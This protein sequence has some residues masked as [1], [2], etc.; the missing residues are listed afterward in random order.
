MAGRLFLFDLGFF[1]FHRF[2]RID[3]NGGFFVSRLKRSRIQKSSKSFGNG[4]AAPFPW[5]ASGST[6][7]S[8]GCTE[9]ISTWR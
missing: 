3:E 8:R 6:M 7:W 5:K 2:A 9:N 1:K 4:A